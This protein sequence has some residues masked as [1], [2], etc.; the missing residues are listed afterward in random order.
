GRARAVP[1]ADLHERDVGRALLG[2]REGLGEVVGHH[3]PV[4]HHLGEERPRRRVLRD[5]E[6]GDAQPPGAPRQRSLERARR[7]GPGGGALVTAVHAITTSPEK[8]RRAGPRIRT[9]RVSGVTV[10]SSAPPGNTTLMGSLNRP[11]PL[12]PPT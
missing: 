1:H 8:T 10:I 5:R 4:A 12:S 6:H 3:Q 7:R 9:S 11:P 2:E